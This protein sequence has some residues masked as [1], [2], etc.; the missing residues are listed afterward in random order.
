[1]SWAQ[2]RQASMACSPNLEYRQSFVGVK[3]IWNANGVTEV[4]GASIGISIFEL[5][6]RILPKLTIVKQ[7][8]FALANVTKGDVFEG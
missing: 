6:P 2:P 8:L 4:A 5:R 7:D 3:T 1:M